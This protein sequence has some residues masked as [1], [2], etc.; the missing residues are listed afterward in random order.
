M[1][2]ERKAAE[3]E[4]QKDRYKKALQRVRDEGKVAVQAG[5]RT[6]VGMA[7]AFGTSYVMGRY[8]DKAKVFGIDL[9]LLA[10]VA[11]SAVGAFNLAGDKQT[12][13]MLEAA[14]LGA[15]C[16]YAARRGGE[17]GAEAKNS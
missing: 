14:G 16:S 10:G 3:L 9:D 8:P 6:G 7:S 4:V 17:M 1:L 5:I 11:G 15:L 13:E 2:S 12:S